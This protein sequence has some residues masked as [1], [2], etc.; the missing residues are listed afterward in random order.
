MCILVTRAGHA[1]KDLKIVISSIQNKLAERIT[2]VVVAVEGCMNVNN[3]RSKKQKA[4]YF[5]HLLQQNAWPLFPIE[6]SSPV[7]VCLLQLN[8]SLGMLCHYCQ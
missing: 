3:N 4:Q 5:L 2:K 6:S 8:N 1:C 7:V